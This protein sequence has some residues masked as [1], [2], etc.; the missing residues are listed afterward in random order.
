MKKI[1]FSLVLILFTTFIFA[2][3]YTLQLSNNNENVKLIH[4]SAERLILE[5]QTNSLSFS[6][7]ENEKGI[8]TVLR[9]DNLMGNNDLGLPELPY[10]GKIITVPL[11]A[12]LQVNTLQ[13]ITRDINL[14]NLGFNYP[15]YPAQPSQR[16]TAFE[17]PETLFIYHQEQYQNPYY[18]T[19]FVPFQTKEIGFLRGY[20]LFEII[21]TPIQY[22]PVENTFV[23]FEKLE[24]EIVFLHADYTQT[25][26]LRAKTWSPEFEKLSRSFILNYQSPQIRNTLER[27]PAKY[28]IIAHHTLAESMQPFITWKVLQGFEV[29]MENTSNPAV[30]STT[31]SIK[32]YIQGLWDSATPEDPAPSYLLLVGDHQQIPAWNTQFT[33]DYSGHVTDLNYVRLEGNDYL[34]EMYYGRFSAQNVNQLLPQIEKTLMYEQFTMPD[35]DYLGRALLIAGNDSYWAPRNANS[36]INYLH[37]NYIHLN[38]NNHQ[39][40]DVFVSLYPATNSNVS[41]IRNFIYAG[42]GYINYTAHGDWDEWSGQSSA[43]FNKTHISQMINVDKYPVM[44]G[45]CCLTNKF[46]MDECFGEALLRAPNKGAALYIGGTNSTYWDEDYWWTIGSYPSPGPSSGAAPAYD[47]NKLGM[48]DMLFH[49]QGE[50]TNNWHTSAGAMIWAGNMVIQAGSSASNMKGYYWEIY[51]IMGDPSL[52]P[53]LGL[54]EPNFAEYPNQLL[55]GF[56]ELTITNSAPFSRVSLSMNNEL[57][58]TMIT[59]EIG[60]GLL[61]FAPLTLPGNAELVITA[62]NYQPLFDTISVIPADQPYLIFQHVLNPETGDTSVNFTSQSELIWT[63]KNV[64]LQPAI[65]AVITITTTSPGVTIL[66][67][68]QIVDQIEPESLYTHAEPICLQVSE[69]FA[70]DTTI[71]ILLNVQIDDEYHWSIPILIPINASFIVQDT[72]AIDDSND[73]NNGRLDPG[74][75]ALINLHLLNTG[76]ASS[77][78][79]KITVAS[80]NPD[81]HLFLDSD[82][83]TS[84]AKDQELFFPI[85]V[86]AENNISA[87]SIANITFYIDFQN[88]QI[89]KYYTLSI[90]QIV[91][92]FSL[93]DFSSLDWT[94]GANPW[95]IVS[96]E[97]Y[98]GQ[99]SARSGAISHSQVSILEI[100]FSLE[101]EGILQF[102]Y[103]VSSEAVNDRLQFYLNNNT[104]GN[105]SGEIDWTEASFNIPAGN[106]TF[107]WVYRKNENNSS[108][109]DAAWLDNIIFPSSGGEIFSPLAFVSLEEIDFGH[110]AINEAGTKTFTLINLGNTFLE[111][112][113]VIPEGILLHANP[114]FLLEAYK[115]KVYTLTF[116]SSEPQNLEQ[117]LIINTNDPNNEVITIQLNGQVGTVHEGDN[118]IAPLLTSLKNNYPNPFNPETTL[119]FDLQQDTWVTLDIYNIKGQKVRSLIHN[120][121]SSGYHKIIWNG[122]DNMNRDVATGLYFYQMTAGDYFAVKKM[123]L[124]K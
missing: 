30:G 29:I 98:V 112:S 89:Q 10:L 63:I 67:E 79:S 14:S 91:E 81:V 8:F 100:Q 102:H 72:I 69:N 13:S 6:E 41:N 25:E 116:Q 28:L 45:N 115:N 95:Q 84:L 120:Y 50:D 122:K 51:S 5:Y 21:Y 88:Q 76:K 37:E 107:R 99:Y 49:T 31:T 11:G 121:L 90:G 53:Y 97:H 101:T 33:G 119:A 18:Q 113:F 86:Q 73:N 1:L 23:L 62:Q 7:Q 52:V 68:Q 109:N 64:G 48:Y 57:L 123:I 20:R 42:A 103:K 38:G 24:I 3:N 22:N 93:G 71:E 4:N 27:I 46:E 85:Q 124:L 26:Y 94:H 40:N 110:L 75:T 96:E 56:N 74:E 16:K 43:L 59:N 61:Q 58:G 44:I 36:Q 15:I 106:H 35:P 34:P 47:P 54:P 77:L 117:V 2:A 104:I 111:G 55:L 82:I 87:G 12:S 114:N 39:F 66:T 83:I 19:D 118:P 17:N 105:W 92:D 32:N 70:N 60:A 78:P 108:G 9:A 65:N 80:T